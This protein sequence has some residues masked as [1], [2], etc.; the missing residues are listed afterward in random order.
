MR[1]R[2]FN[3]VSA[4]LLTTAGLVAC[5][6]D[7]D[8]RGA[9][10]G[11]AGGA[12]VGLT[13]GALTGDANLA[14]KG[15]VAGGV[16]GGVAGSMSDLESDRDTERT[17]MLANSIASN[18]SGGTAP[19]TA[20][21][22]DNWERLNVF[23]GNWTCN[24]W[25]LNAEGT[26]QTATATFTGSLQSTSAARLSMTSFDAADFGDSIDA[27]LTG[28]TEISYAPGS[29]YQL[30]NVF[31]ATP[32]SHRWVGERMTGEERYSFYYTG[33]SNAGQAGRPLS[34]Q[35]MEMRFVG[36][37][38]FFVDTFAP[39]PGGAEVQIQSYRFTRAN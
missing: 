34:D 22:Q 2:S 37:D 17:A 13:M 36:N 20:P 31:T 16:A 14:M 21:R 4:L 6:A 5:N 30:L 10:R 28:Y 19:G 7:A 1:T 35:R 38:V 33:T 3:L 11:A 26:R 8:N 27:G 18:N 29:G 9:K 25:G 23:P 32:D 39:G 24:I 15:A 12:L